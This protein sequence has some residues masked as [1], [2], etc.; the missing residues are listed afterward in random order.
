ME[1]T[2]VQPAPN[3]ANRIFKKATIA[4]P[5]KYLSNFWRS[6]EMLLINCKAA[7][8]VNANDKSNNICFTV[9]GTKLYVPDAT[10]SA[11]DNQKLSK[12]LSKWSERSFYPN[13]YKTKSESKNRTNEYRYFLKWNFVGVNKFFLLAC[14]TQDANAKRFYARK[15]YLSKI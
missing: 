6:L 14:T 5:L 11:K 10:L 12:L 1:N 4:V 15:Y 9:K 2:G 7:G 3:Q 8:A 13:E